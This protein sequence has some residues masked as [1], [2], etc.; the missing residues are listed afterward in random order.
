M[1]AA[2][3]RTWTAV[4]ESVSRSL[5]NP[6]STSIARLLGCRPARAEGSPAESGAAIPG[7]R[8]V[9]S[10]PPEAWTLRGEHRFSQYS[11][12]FRIDE[13]PGGRSLLSAETHARFPGIAGGAYRTAVI[14]TRGHVLAT[15]RM[16]RAA[17]HRAETG[18]AGAAGA[19]EA[20][21]AR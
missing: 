5:S 6:R 2:P 8:V 16:L 11:L 4:V 17:K 21:G 3:E 10:D 13:R 7:F 9:A 14:G 19:A 18:A 12:A 1:E 15:R 20:P